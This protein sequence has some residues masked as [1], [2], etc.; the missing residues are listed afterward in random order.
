LISSVRNTQDKRWQIRQ[1]G[2]YTRPGESLTRTTNHNQV[3]VV[4]GAG[5]E[6][7]QVVQKEGAT[8]EDICTATHRTETSTNLWELEK[9]NT[10]GDQS[11]RPGAEIK[12]VK[13]R[14]NCDEGT[15]R[16]D[17]NTT[18]NEGTL[19]EFGV[20]YSSGIWM[21]NKLPSENLVY[22]GAGGTDH[23]MSR[24]QSTK[25]CLT[26]HDVKYDDEEE[27]PSWDDGK[28]DLSKPEKDSWEYRD[29]APQPPLDLQAGLTAKELYL[30]DAKVLTLFN[31]WKFDFVSIVITV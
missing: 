8:T 25:L 20:D 26:R 28:N 18:L 9:E 31:Q 3:D 27:R 14:S 6:L 21:W 5:L 16:N 10:W 24:W 12:F 7:K 17:I 4:V 1:G 13:V 2:G 29:V 15:G 19:S 30:S 11:K 23:T 22:H